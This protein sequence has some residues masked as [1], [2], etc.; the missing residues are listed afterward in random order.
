M[1]INR[2]STDVNPWIDV[3]ERAVT[4][5]FTILIAGFVAY[6]SRLQWKTNREKL[7]LDLYERRFDI[8]MR[9][10]EFQSA[11][12][13]WGGGP[14]QIA[15]Q[16]PF[17]RALQESRFMFPEKSGAYKFLI[18]FNGHAFHVVNYQSAWDAWGESCPKNERN[19]PWLATSM[20]IG[21][22]RLR[23]SSRS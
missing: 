4:P 19:S 21:Y 17:L 8:Y 3:I 2:L 14:E 18:E 11:L 23:G 1:R 9:V 10:F 7:R 20:S 6:I 22:S 5:V 13:F 15:L 16:A 12:L